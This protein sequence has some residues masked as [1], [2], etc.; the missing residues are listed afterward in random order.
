LSYAQKKENKQNKRKAHHTCIF[1]Y[2][3]FLNIFGVERRRRKKSCSIASFPIAVADT[4]TCFKDEEKK[5][6]ST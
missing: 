6:Y 4:N 1:D 2:L 5:V 3:F